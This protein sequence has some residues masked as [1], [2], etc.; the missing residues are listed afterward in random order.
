MKDL[1]N[2]E[3]PQGLK[4][5][6]LLGRFAAPFGCAQGRLRHRGHRKEKIL[7]EVRLFMLFADD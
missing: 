1:V 3:L 6:L 7:F 4:P 5:A 2:I